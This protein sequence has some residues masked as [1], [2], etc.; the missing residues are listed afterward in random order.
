MT[1]FHLL[2]HPDT[3]R[4]VIDGRILPGYESQKTVRASSWIDAKK[5]LGFEL[6]A[7]QNEMLNAQNNRNEANRGVV[8]NLENARVKFRPANYQL[9][10]RGETSEDSRECVLQLLRDEG[11]LHHLCPRS[12]PSTT[13]E[14]CFD[15]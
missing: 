5:R 10:D 6:T 9:P 3:N 7:L 12:G 4:L 15:L 1:T 8:K 13:E 2:W 11:L 14:A